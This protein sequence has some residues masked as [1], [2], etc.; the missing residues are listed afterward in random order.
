MRKLRAVFSKGRWKKDHKH[1][2]QLD[3]LLE[4]Y[5]ELLLGEA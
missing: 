2:E 5:T 1:Q 4:K 3:G